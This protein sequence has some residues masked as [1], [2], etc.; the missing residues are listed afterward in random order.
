MSSTIQ[1]LATINCHTRCCGRL[2]PK[3][4]MAGQSIIAPTASLTPADAAG[5]FSPPA[6]LRPLS[7]LN[8]P[9]AATAHKAAG[10]AVEPRVCTTAKEA[11]TAASTPARHAAGYAAKGTHTSNSEKL[12]PPS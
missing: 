3:S 10:M 12:M 2:A 8:P 6:A 4:D 5:S 9:Q 1:R 7:R 11:V